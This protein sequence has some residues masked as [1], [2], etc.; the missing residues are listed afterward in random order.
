M[1]FL[2][3]IDFPDSHGAAVALRACE[4]VEGLLT[5]GYCWAAA[6]LTLAGPRANGARR[7]SFRQKVSVMRP[8]ICSRRGRAQRICNEHMRD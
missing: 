6:R 1:C 4:R 7:A 8:G 2:F 5:G 3:V